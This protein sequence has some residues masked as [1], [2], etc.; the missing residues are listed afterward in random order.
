[1][2]YWA[3]AV[4]AGLVAA[5]VGFGTA[6]PAQAACEPDK[7]ATKYPGLAGKTLKVGLDPTLPPIMYRDPNNPSK[8]IGQDPD[9]IEAAMKCLGLK[10]ELV[11]LDFGTLVPT[12]QA[13]QIQLIWSNIYYTPARAQAADFVNYA[14]T[15]TAGIVK[16]G[17][18]KGIKT[19]DDVCGKRAAPILGTVEDKGFQ[20]AS[21][22]CVAAGKPAIEITPYPNAPATSRAIENDRADLSMYDVVLVDQVVRSN[23]DKFERAYYFRSN[24]KVGVAV[25]KG[26]E[27]L[28][29]AV[30]DAIT[31]LQANG[32]QKALMQKNG[33]DPTLAIPVE[34]GR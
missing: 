30:K 21:A 26:N 7:V 34:I 3:G 5:T 4:L 10:Y 24:I 11:G 23:P 28:V 9:M 17:N 29:T 25:K 33:I 8:I 32:T 22:K 13:G 14:T 6:R 16:K 2:R 31:E 1:M 27:E 12:L 20:D 15:G 18:P 19:I